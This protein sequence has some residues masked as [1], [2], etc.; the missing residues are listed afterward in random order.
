MNVATKEKCVRGRR[1][2][3]ND[4]ITISLGPVKI[5]NFEISG[6]T[7]TVLRR[8]VGASSIDVVKSPIALVHSRR[9]L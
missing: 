1:G 6:A 5:S 7:Q 3:R 9:W 8:N 4:A 2:L